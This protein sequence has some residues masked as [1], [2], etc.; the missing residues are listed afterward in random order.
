MHRTGRPVLIVDDN[1][2]V[3]EV[4]AFMVSTAG[5]N[6]ETAADG[7][8]ALLKLRASRPC[9]VVLDLMMPEMDGESFRRA[10]LADDDEAVR[11]IPVVCYSA[12]PDL[13][14]TAEEMG[15]AYVEKTGEIGELL[16]EIRRRCTG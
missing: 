3:R 4:L 15:V 16:L 11:A 13:R 2:D 8:E 14:Q 10:Q 9:V 6:V 1:D 7:R 12:A 5:F